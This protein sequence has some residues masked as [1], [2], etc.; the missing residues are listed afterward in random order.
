MTKN[1]KKAEHGDFQTPE[2]LARQVCGFLKKNSV[3]PKSV[4]EPTC[5]AGTF[6]IEALNVFDEAREG[7][8]CD[9]DENYIELLRNRLPDYGTSTQVRIETADFFSKDWESELCDLPEPILVIGNPPWITN[10]QLGQLGS[11]NLPVKLNHKKMKGLDALTGK[12]NFDISEWMIDRM[13]EWL[14]KKRGTVA[15]LCKTSVARKVLLNAWKNERKMEVATMHLIDS[16]LHFRISADACLLTV[17]SS[18]RRREDC[19]VYSHMEADSPIQTIG[20]REGFLVADIHGYEKTRHLIENSQYYKWRT[21]IKHDCSK[22]MELKKTGDGLYV[23]GLGEINE[24]EDMCLY[25][26]LKG[27]GLANRRDPEKFMLVPQTRI[28]QETGYLAKAAPKTMEYLKKYGE[29]LDRRTSSIYRDKPRFSVF[30]V[31]DYSFSNWK[32]AIAALYKKL[33]F[34]VVGPHEGK[35]VV[36]DDTV[37]FFAMDSP[38]ESHRLADLLNSD[39]ANDFYSSFIFWDSK[40]PITVQLL[41]SLD[42]DR[43]SAE[44]GDRHKYSIS[45]TSRQLLLIQ[46]Y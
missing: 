27:S 22:V 34:F 31:G 18:D 42:I 32:V 8:A 35:A 14:Q 12:S 21:G 28:G 15:M 6:F 43:L 41:R 33:E 13:I 7:Y 45:K 9:I 5:G 3:A 10:S 39:T 17:T 11:E 37:N 40:R 16:K 1:T 23:N 2:D 25:P 46:G 19:K 44:S 38:E 29:L 20:L 4:I 26:L 36:F 30:G 24:L